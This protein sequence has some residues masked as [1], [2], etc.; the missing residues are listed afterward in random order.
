MRTRTPKRRLAVFVVDLR[1]GIDPTQSRPVGIAAGRS[2]GRAACGA[3]DRSHPSAPH[4]ARNAVVEGLLAFGDGEVAGLGHVAIIA[5]TD[6][7]VCQANAESC[8]GIF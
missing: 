5:I 8:V 1:D 2:I 3:S 6:A 7:C 4:A